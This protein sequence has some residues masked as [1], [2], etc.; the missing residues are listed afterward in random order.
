MSAR[1]H[2]TWVIAGAGAA[3][4]SL[5]VHLRRAGV[6]ARLVLVDPRSDYGDDR[7][8]CGFR[9]HPHPFDECVSMRWTRWEVRHD[10]HVHRGGS[11]RYPYEHIPA[12][13]FYARALSLLEPAEGVERVRARVEALEPTGDRVRVRTSAGEL[14]AD[15]V[16]DGRPLPLTATPIEP[17]ARSINRSISS[18]AGFVQHFGGLLVEFARPVFDPTSATLMDFRPPQEVPGFDSRGSLR[19][20]Y[21]LPFDARRALIED[22]YFTPADRFET[23]SPA[24]Y[25]RGLEELLEELAPRGGDHQVLRR[26]AGALPMIPGFGERPSPHI[27][28]IGLRGGAA[29]PAT[30]YAFHFIQRHSAAL[31]RFARAAG[32][33]DWRKAPR[34]RSAYRDIADEVF[35]RRLHDDPA[36]APALFLHLFD[37][38]S[39]DQLARFLSEASHPHEDLRLM[40]A[41]P[42][43]AMSGAA[44]RTLLERTRLGRPRSGQTRDPLRASEPEPSPTTPA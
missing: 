37:S 8:W 3:G 23:L 26:E 35:L 33:R 5:A 12:A 13:R 31:A 29:K 36:S 2:E 40:A 17:P 41:M 9:T 1:R 25:A 10:G 34:S 42:T 20:R 16:F 24:L 19:F 18:F 38:T 27:T 28:P 43:R 39:S 14:W 7:T 11:R 6:D 4:L 15:H 21:V 32:A 44:A 22:T 30:G